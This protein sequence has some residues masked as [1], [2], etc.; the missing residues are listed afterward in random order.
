MMV[1]KGAWL[2][3]GGELLQ[4]REELGL[5]QSPRRVVVAKQASAVFSHPLAQVGELARPSV[6]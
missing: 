1:R 3:R 4:P 5:H 6:Y 2:G